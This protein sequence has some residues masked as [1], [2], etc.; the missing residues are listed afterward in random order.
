MVRMK[1][2][3][4]KEEFMSKLWMLKP[5]QMKFKK[6][7]ITNDYTLDERMI[8]KDYVEEAKKRNMI[9]TKEYAW[10][11]RGTPREGMKLIKIKIHE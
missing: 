6:L 8:I 7:S 9:G 2:I 3:N 4:E 5:V 11:V 1:S 10:K